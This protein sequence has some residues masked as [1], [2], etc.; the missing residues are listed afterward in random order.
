MLC[1][2]KWR[3]GHGRNTQILEQLSVALAKGPIV[4]QGTER[5]GTVALLSWGLN[6]LVWVC[7]LVFFPVCWHCSQD[8]PLEVLFSHEQLDFKLQRLSCSHFP[9]ELQECR[10]APLGSDGNNGKVLLDSILPSLCPFPSDRADRYGFCFVAPLILIC[11]S[12]F[13]NRKH[14]KFCTSYNV[15]FVAQGDITEN[16]PFLIFFIFL[17]FISCS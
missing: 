7:F 13:L 6:F 14:Q 11:S 8:L 17:L 16:S 1:Y 4:N 3:L 10:Q 9:Q 2:S 15:Y 12:I 5:R